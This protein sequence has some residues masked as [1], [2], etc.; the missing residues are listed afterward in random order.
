MIGS[1]CF[2]VLS[3]FFHPSPLVIPERLMSNIL[4]VA[5]HTP[6]LHFFRNQVIELRKRLSKVFEF[7]QYLLFG[8]SHALPSLREIPSRIDD[9][10]ANMSRASPTSRLEWAGIPLVKFNLPI[11][12]DDKLGPVS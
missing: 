11:W 4:P 8:R 1:S 5:I 2:L 9:F 3:C 7:R 12:K 6:A 10:G